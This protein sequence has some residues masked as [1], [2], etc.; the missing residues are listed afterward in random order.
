MCEACRIGPPH[1]QDQDAPPYKPAPDRRYA[2]VACRA[3]MREGP[4]AVVGQARS[5]RDESRHLAQLGQSRAAHCDGAYFYLYHEN[6]VPGGHHNGGT[7]MD[8]RD[9]GVNRILLHVFDDHDLRSDHDIA[10]G[11]V[12]RRPLFRD[13]EIGP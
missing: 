9:H 7:R 11:Q 13:A 1:K 3:D 4:A 12:C 8:G 5:G 2:F 6:C 10:R